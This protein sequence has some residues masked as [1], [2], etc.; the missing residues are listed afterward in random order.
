[1]V[2]DEIAIRIK[3]ELKARYDMTR[4]PDPVFARIAE[5]HLE[6][7]DNENGQTNQTFR[8]ATRAALEEV[9]GAGFQFKYYSGKK[10]NILSTKRNMFIRS[11]K[12]E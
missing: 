8:Y 5:K 6:Y 1:M 11:E 3:E 4:D 10:E 9:S 7:D 2:A 12:S